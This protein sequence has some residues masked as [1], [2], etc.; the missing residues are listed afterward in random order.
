MLSSDKI[1]GNAII[2]QNI[3]WCYDWINI[4]GVMIELDKYLMMLGLD[5]YLIMLSGQNIGGV[6]IGY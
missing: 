6:I 3:W 5:K 2:G 1:F 4:C